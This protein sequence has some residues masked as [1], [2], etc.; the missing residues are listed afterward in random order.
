MYPFASL[1]ENLIAFCA[2]LRRDH[3]FRIGPGELHDAARALEVVDLSDEHAVRHALR[4]TLSGTLHDATVF[5][6]A[7]ADFFF[8]RPFGDR[9][10]QRPSVRRD[11]ESDAVSSEERFEQ[12]RRARSPVDA[13]AVDVAPE[14]PDGPI[15]P[16]ETTDSDL[17]EAAP[18]AHDEF[19][20]EYLAE[21]LTQY[22]QPPRIVGAPEAVIPA[23][24]L[25]PEFPAEMVDALTAGQIRNGRD[26]RVS[27]FQVRPSGRFVKAVTPEGQ[28]VAIGE[29]RLPHLYHPVLVL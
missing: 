17:E 20:L 4:P 21:V 23:A 27:P 12:E 9:H 2:V 8:P 3:G 7:F 10:D 14:A 18:L 28:L 25:L 5:D 19:N 26:F 24:Q 11:P 1:P 16:L 22:G 29:A 15:A 13:D 6:Q